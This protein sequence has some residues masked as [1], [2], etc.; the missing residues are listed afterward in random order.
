MRPMRGIFIVAA[1]AVGPIALALWLDTRLGD[2][3]P[4]SPIW[5]IAHAAAAYAAVTVASRTF[6][7]LARNDAPVSEQ[8]LV[9]TF[10]LVPAFAYAYTCVLWLCRTLA[11]VAKLGRL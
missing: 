9:V 3:R 7:T 8:T 1:V 10:L 11:E 5:R 4:T 6:G 2:R